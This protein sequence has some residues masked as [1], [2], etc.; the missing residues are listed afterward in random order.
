MIKAGG[1]EY[2]VPTTVRFDG[3]HMVLTDFIRPIPDYPKPGILFR[4]ITPLLGNADTLGQAVH[5][6]AHPYRDAGITSVVAIEARGFIL[7]GAVATKLHAGFV[8]LRKPG[9]L[10]HETV[11]EPYEL[12]Y[13]MD[14]L[15]MHTDALKERDRV[16]LIDDLIAT[17]GTAK[18]A[19]ALI[20]Q[21]GAELVAAGFVIDLP[22]LR[23]AERIRSL[24]HSVTTLME[25]PGH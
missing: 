1:N 18:A 16:L 21:S 17:G 11:S 15:H 23:G 20:E 6:L 13:G 10:P 5:D 8:P 4:D 7:G 12:E 2:A 3:G 25:F 19:L 22:D 14:E 24:G 9:K